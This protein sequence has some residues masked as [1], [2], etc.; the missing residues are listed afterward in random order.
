LRNPKQFD[1]IV[2][3]NLFG[4]ILSDEA[5]MLTGS[6]GLL[7]SAS[8]GAKNKN[9]SMRSMYE[10]VHGSAPDI[11]GEGK[12]NPLAM[13]MSF[14]MML[15][16]S[17]DMSEDALLIEQAVQNLLSKGFRTPDIKKDNQNAVTTKEMGKAV[18]EELN[19][20]SGK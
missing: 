15:K 20:L 8:L 4:D 3:D 18:V 9:G 7:P 5:A 14:A 1:V 13:I 12:A 10:P 6:L 19:I 16:Y 17:F 11:A 2:T